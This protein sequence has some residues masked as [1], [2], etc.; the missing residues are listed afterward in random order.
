MSEAGYRLGNA[1]GSI[2]SGGARAEGETRLGKELAQ[3]AAYLGQAHLARARADEIEGRRQYQRPEFA[4]RLA[5]ALAGLTDPQAD[6]AD[7]FVRSGTWGKLP[8]ITLPEEQA[9][10]VAPER[11]KEAPAWATP[12]TMA[13]FQRGRSAH[14]ANLGGTGDTS[15]EGLVKAFRELQERGDFE[16]AQANPATIPTYGAAVAASKGSPLWHQGAN[17]PMQLFTGQENLNDVGR[18]VIA[19]NQAQAL[20][21][22]A[23]AGAS[24]AKAALDRS[25]IGQPQVVI[26]PDGEPVIVA[27][28]IKMSATEQKETFEADDL[29]AAGENTV[30]ML[31]QALALN[32]HAYSGV[33]AKAR[34]VIRSNLPGEDPG[35]NATID[36]DNLMT[37][38]ALESL[39][40]TFGA[41]PTEGERKI[42]MD[43]QASA[44]KTPTQRK[45][46]IERAIVLAE[47]RA[48]RNRDKA[49]ALREGTYLSSGYVRPSAGSAQTAQQAPAGQ[50]AGHPA[51]ANVPEAAVAHL[52]A[53][54]Q[55]RNA[56]AAKYGKAA[57][58]AALGLK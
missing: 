3:Q 10:P 40:A 47:R 48:E 13:S 46:I 19:E 14:L 7:A 33:G 30:G 1:L 18:S 52:K 35:A 53:N 42:L 45:A 49:R 26:G 5:G 43:L 9:G 31:R 55:L 57:T 21:Q 32:D 56:F 37:G 20:A 17:G 24:S 34:A 44:D 25:K 4:S 39:K 22:R 15:G 41:A 12:Q 27:P 54:P 23:A 50:A 2:L 51:L 16:A 6:E 29:A 36:L 8:A 11:E 28:R 38:Q 58:D